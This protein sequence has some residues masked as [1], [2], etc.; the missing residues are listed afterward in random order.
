VNRDSTLKSARNQLEIYD[1]APTEASRKKNP[2]WELFTQPGFV[3]P[4]IPL[5]PP[6]SKVTTPHRFT[7]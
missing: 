5:Y 1:R 4:V 2:G 7:F 3:R 6:E